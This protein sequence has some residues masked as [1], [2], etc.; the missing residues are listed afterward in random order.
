MLL[1]IVYREANQLSEEMGKDTE[2]A[3][4][5]QIPTSSLSFGRSRS[6]FSSEVAIVVKHKTKGTQSKLL[7]TKSTL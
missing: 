7:R 3:V 5:L 4:T 1:F 6:G 2:F